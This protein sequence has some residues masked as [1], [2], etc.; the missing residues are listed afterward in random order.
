MTAAAT[1]GTV[2]RSGVTDAKSVGVKRSWQDPAI[3]QRRIDAMRERMATPEFK[4]S[5]Q[6]VID[7]ARVKVPAWVPDD[8]APEYRELAVAD[9]EEVAARHCR[10]LKREMDEPTRSFAYAGAPA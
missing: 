8:L 3:R 10:R 5:Y 6:R 9:G 2:A 1:R 7:T 4:A